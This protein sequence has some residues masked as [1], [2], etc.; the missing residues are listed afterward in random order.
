MLLGEPLLQFMRIVLLK[1]YVFT[2][3]QVDDWHFLQLI[4]V[5]EI[6]VVIIAASSE[7]FS[8]LSPHL[9]LTTS[10]SHLE[11]YMYDIQE[12]SLGIPRLL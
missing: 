1:M 2:V 11:E 5:G 10:F 7:V 3:D 9:L 8:Y 6:C 12:K 4:V